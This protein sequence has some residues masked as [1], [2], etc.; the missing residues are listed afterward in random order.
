MQKMS[1]GTFLIALVSVTLLGI[2]IS[3]VIKWLFPNLKNQS[4]SASEY[5][6]YLLQRGG[7]RAKGTL[8][9]LI[10]LG[11]AF[12][13]FSLRLSVESQRKISKAMHYGRYRHLDV[14]FDV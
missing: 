8:A 7:R 14:N 10:G 5:T 13:L 1:L 12:L 3:Y 4:M 11:A 6:E 2:G 9:I